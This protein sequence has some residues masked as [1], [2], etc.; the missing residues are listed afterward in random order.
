[1]K[2]EIKTL[3]DKIDSQ[4]QDFISLTNMSY[5]ICCILILFIVAVVYWV[6]IDSMSSVGHLALA[7][8]PAWSD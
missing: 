5:F 3:K 7:L 4:E 1:M 8:T 2:D 6:Q